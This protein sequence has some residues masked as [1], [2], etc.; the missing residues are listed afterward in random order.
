MSIRGATICTNLRV[1]V[2]GVV[3]AG[4][5]VLAAVWHQQKV[6]PDKYRQQ[7]VGEWV[8]DAP[9]AHV[10]GQGVQRSSQSLLSLD[11][12]RFTW[13]SVVFADDKTAAGP[14]GAKLFA[15]DLSGSY[16]MGAL[17][18]VAPSAVT[19]DLRREKLMVTPLSAR[20]V[21]DLVAA[22]CQGSNTASWTVGVQR[23]LSGSCMGVPS[24]SQCGTE[25]DIVTIRANQT[26]VFGQRGL[27][28]PCTAQDRSAVIGKH[29][30]SRV[31]HSPL[32]SSKAI[33]Q[34]WLSSSQ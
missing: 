2:I 20:G 26:L 24:S 19:V 8:S 32:A 27:Q 22:N 1:N 33:R 14:S 5:L 13:L 9:Q 10:D 25:F 12:T 28:T 23:A 31:E 29:T 16:S 7:I 34:Q 15:L 21:A 11:G 6:L 17:S 30:L 4:A 3:I 18:E